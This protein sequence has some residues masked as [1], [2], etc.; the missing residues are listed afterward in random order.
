MKQ[1]PRF[2]IAFARHSVSFNYANRAVFDTVAHYCGGAQRPRR[3]FIKKAARRSQRPTTAADTKLIVTCCFD[4]A[5]PL[6]ATQ[7]THWPAK[8]LHTQMHSSGAAAHTQNTIMNIGLG[9]LVFAVY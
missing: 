5:K 7:R 2:V 4:A 3:A 9:N 8:L 6:F 1:L